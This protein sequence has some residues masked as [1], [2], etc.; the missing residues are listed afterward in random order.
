[1]DIETQSLKTLNWQVCVLVADL[2]IMNPIV[3]NPKL[4]SAE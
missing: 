3:T 2:D 1:M 4:E